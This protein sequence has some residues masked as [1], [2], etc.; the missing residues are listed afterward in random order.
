[1]CTGL[2]TVRVHQVVRPQFCCFVHETQIYNFAH[3]NRIN[4]HWATFFLLYCDKGASYFRRSG[5]SANLFSLSSVGYGDSPALA[6]VSLV[7]LFLYLSVLSAQCSQYTATTFDSTRWAWG[8]TDKNRKR[9]YVTVRLRQVK[10]MTKSR[11]CRRAMLRLIIRA[12]ISF[13]YG[14]PCTQNTD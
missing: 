10:W 3:I 11:R 2:R 8:T 1:M 13:I 7:S 9:H 5:T 12:M 4:F 14:S 6:T